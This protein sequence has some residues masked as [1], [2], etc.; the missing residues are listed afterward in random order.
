MRVVLDTNVLLV[1]IP[2]KSPYRLIF[3]KILDGT[4]VIAVSNDIIFEYRE[5]ISEKSAPHIAENILNGFEDRPNVELHV[6]FYK[7]SLIEKDP[8]DNKFIDCYIKSGADYLVSNDR[9]FNVLKTDDFPPVKVISID[10]FLE[11]LQE[12]APPVKEPEG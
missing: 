2:R 7:W 3:D 10:R 11:L 4:L 5:V 9:H 8:D 1:S 6:P 12:E